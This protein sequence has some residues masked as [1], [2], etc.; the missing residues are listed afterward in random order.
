MLKGKG[1]GAKTPGAP[2]LYDKT[3]EELRKVLEDRGQYTPDLYMMVEVAATLFTRISLLMGE[4]LADGHSSVNVE[5]SRE[6][7]ERVVIDPRE[8]LLLDY[9]KQV[10]AVAKMLGMSTESKTRGKD[11]GRSGFD[12]FMSDFKDD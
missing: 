7:N 2:K 5:L 4:I 10:V 12:E 8:G 6:G 9:I 1:R 3:R 11:S